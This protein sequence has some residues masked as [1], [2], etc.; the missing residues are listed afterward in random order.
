MGGEAIART[1][2]RWWDYE[3][4]RAEESKRGRLKLE[5]RVGLGRE[6]VGRVF[7]GCGAGGRL[8]RHKSSWQGPDEDCEIKMKYENQ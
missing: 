8:F 6:V 5:A 2:W 4:S 3:S 7:V 1:T